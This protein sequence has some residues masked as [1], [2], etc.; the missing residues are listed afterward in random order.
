MTWYGMFGP[1]GLPPD[2]VRKLHGEVVKIVRL[3]DVKERLDALG[4]DETASASPEEFAAMVK[5][6]VAKTTKVIKAEPADGLTT[7]HGEQAPRATPALAFEAATCGPVAGAAGVPGELSPRCRP[8]VEH[9]RTRLPRI[10]LRCAA[11]D[12]GN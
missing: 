11:P 3:P 7:R 10:W 4:A 9:D 6:D 12:S 5:S 2:I 8:P 1:A